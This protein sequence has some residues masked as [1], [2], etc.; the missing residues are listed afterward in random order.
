M[1]AD[2]W[3]GWT[4]LKSLGMEDSVDIFPFAHLTEYQLTNQHE[5]TFWRSKMAVDKTV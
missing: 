4:D 5:K 2:V 1:F 3:I